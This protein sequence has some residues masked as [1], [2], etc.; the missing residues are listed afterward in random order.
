MKAHCHPGT[1]FS[2][3]AFIRIG[4]LEVPVNQPMSKSALARIGGLLPLGEAMGL[5]SVGFTEDSFG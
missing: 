4:V 3:A 5:V 1:K 2:F